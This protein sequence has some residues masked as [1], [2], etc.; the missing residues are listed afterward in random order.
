[1][2]QKHL[3]EVRET[4]LGDFSNKFPRAGEQNNPLLPPTDSNSPKRN[5]GVETLLDQQLSDAAAYRQKSANPFLAA[6]PTANA[7]HSHVNDDLTAK[8]LGLPYYGVKPQTNSV[9]PA[10]TAQS[11]AAEWDPFGANRMKPKF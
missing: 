8:A 3:E 7:L 4:I 9:R 11:V 6:D 2:Q 5:T 1:M 10:P